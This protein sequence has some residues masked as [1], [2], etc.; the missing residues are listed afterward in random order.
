MADDC[1]AADLIATPRI[2]TRKPFVVVLLLL[3]RLD[4]VVPM[5][6]LSQQLLHFYIR[7]S[8]YDKK[9]LYRLREEIIF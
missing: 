2:V 6:R 9:C 7:D 3:E 5:E 8:R 4:P 1:V